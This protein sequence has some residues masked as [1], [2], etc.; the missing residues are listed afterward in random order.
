MVEQY[1]WSGRFSEACLLACFPS[2]R[3]GQGG[4]GANKG[5]G[6][7]GDTSKG[8]HQFGVSAWN[9][10]FCSQRGDAGAWILLALLGSAGGECKREAAGMEETEGT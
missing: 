10:S 4:L 9:P 8:S 5:K 2:Q 6:E 1:E 7:N 3:P